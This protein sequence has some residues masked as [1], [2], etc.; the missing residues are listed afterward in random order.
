MQLTRFLGNVMAYLSWEMKLK[1]EQIE[2]NSKKLSGQY[3]FF[4]VF[5][6]SQAAV[7]SNATYGVLQHLSVLKVT[8]G[9]CCLE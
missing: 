4:Y 7:L 6:A 1:W 2:I 5:N 8:D 9:Q 3:F